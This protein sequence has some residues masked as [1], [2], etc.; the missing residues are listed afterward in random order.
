M[1]VEVKVIRAYDGNKVGVK[2]IT[3]SENANMLEMEGKVKILRSIPAHTTK[4]E[5]SHIPKKRY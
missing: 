1:N 5:V 4:K 2:F 3:D